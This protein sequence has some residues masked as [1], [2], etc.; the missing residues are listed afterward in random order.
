MKRKK[1]ADEDS[2]EESPPRLSGTGALAMP[3]ARQVDALSPS[4]KM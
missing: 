4:L 1:Y 3:W 2:D